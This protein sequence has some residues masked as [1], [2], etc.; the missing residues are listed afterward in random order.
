MAA[1]RRLAFLVATA[2]VVFG[3][4]VAADA[5][6]APT[7]SEE[8]VSASPSPL[9]SSIPPGIHTYDE[10]RSMGYDPGMRPEDV[11][12][13][14]CPYDPGWEGLGPGTGPVPEDAPVCVA[15][16]TTFDFGFGIGIPH[17]SYHHNGSFTNSSEYAGGK[18]EVEVRNPSVSHVSGITEFVSNRVLT[19]RPNDEWL[20]TGWV[21][22]SDEGDAQYVYGYDTEEHSW[23]FAKQYDLTFGH[24]YAFRTRGC[25]L[26]GDDRQCGELYWNGLWE[27][28]R[29]SDTADCRPASTPICHVEEYTEIFSNQTSSP[30]PNLTT[31]QGDGKIHW[32]NT[33]VR[34]DIGGSAQWVAWNSTFSDDWYNITPYDTCGEYRY[35][36]FYVVNTG[37]ATCG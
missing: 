22:Y 8:A 12:L 14:L 25:T 16:V 24:Y 4:S 23:N 13:P 11:G 31:N 10:V 5:S 21:E 33:E 30:H 28:I 19:Q 18:V 2:L 6:P 37:Q 29:N 7:P 26:G 32:R 3:V 34:K 9:P 17:A 35:F 1:R 27:L 36:Q 15:D 20:E